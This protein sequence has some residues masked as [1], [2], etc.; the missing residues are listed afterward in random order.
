MGSLGNIS[1]QEAGRNPLD[2]LIA[3]RRKALGIPNPTPGSN[4]GLDLSSVPEEGR[5]FIS[6]ALS[7][8][9]SAVGS[10][11]SK[12]REHRRESLAAMSPEEREVYDRTRETNSPGALSLLSPTGLG[13]SSLAAKTGILRR[14]APFRAKGA[15]LARVV[16]Q[17][18]AT[19]APGVS[20]NVLRMQESSKVVSRLESA[21]YGVWGDGLGGMN[22]SQFSRFMETIPLAE[23]PIVQ[24]GMMLSLQENVAN[25]GRLTKSARQNLLSPAGRVRLE[26]T[27]EG[28]PPEYLNHFTRLVEQGQFQNLTRFLIVAGAAFPLARKAGREIGQKIQGGVY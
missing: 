26:A 24:R 28:L 27:F 18:S 15:R 25:M 17:A 5:G 20:E 4:N 19:R 16:D 13:V 1:S 7:S 23:K 6:Q 10:G 11:I 12:V 3:N 21:G 2:I 14:F 8:V 22:P 9:G